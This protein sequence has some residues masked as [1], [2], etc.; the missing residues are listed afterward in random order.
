MDDVQNLNAAQNG[1][2][3]QNEMSGSE[4]VVSN[5]TEFAKYTIREI[6]PNEIDGLKLVHRRIIC[7]LGTGDTR[8]KGAKLVGNVMGDYHPHG[9]A[10]IYDAIIRLA[11]PFNQVAPYVESEGN[12]GK[13]GGG[14][15]AASRY[16]EV[17]PSEFTKDLFFSNVN[18]KTLT[19]VPNEIGDGYEPAYFVPVIPTALIT[20]AYGISVGYKSMIPHLNLINVCDLVLKWIELKN[21]DKHHYRTRY[22]DYAKYLIPDFPSHGYILNEKELLKEYGI[23]NFRCSVITCGTMEI[24]PTRINIRSIPY[25][26]DF[27]ENTKGKLEVLLKSASF[28]SSDYS[29]IIEMTTGKIL[30]NT[31]ITMKRGVDPF[32]H[33]DQ[34]KKTTSFCKSWTPIWNFCNE[35]GYLISHNPIELVEVWYNARVRSILADLKL[36]NVELVK[37]YRKVSALVIIYDHAKD[38]ANL[39]LKAKNKEETIAP[40][41]KKYNLSQFQAEYIA[42]L[43]IQQFTQQGK[44]ELLNQLTEIKNKIKELQTRFIKIDDIITSQ[45]IKIRDKYKSKCPRRTLIPDFIGALQIVGCGFVQF[46]SIQE[47]GQLISRWGNKDVNVILYPKSRFKLVLEK[48]GVFY[49]EEDTSFQKE[50]SGDVLHVIPANAKYTIIRRKDGTICRIDG[51]YPV[52]EKSTSV[53]YTGD[54]FITVDTDNQVNVTHYSDIV[55]RNNISATGNKSNIKFV[56]G[57]NMNSEYIVVSGNTKDPNILTFERIKPGGKF[58]KLFFGS[59]VIVGVYQP[60]S[61]IAFTVPKEL[62]ARCSVR[63]IYLKNISNILEDE[64]KVLVYLNKKTTSNK[65]TLCLIDKHAD[66]VTIK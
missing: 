60:N 24:H 51:L 66:I 54:D 8:I 27:R 58:T 46:S 13:Y 23:G 32:E 45:I 65:K 48:K 12:V 36:T 53:T 6:L 37:Q 40:L 63:H 57:I 34:L 11:Q 50:F 5:M 20:G 21:T 18:M 38:V 52:K 16:L 29:E 44:D 28:V 42:T 61:E 7:S 59:T 1:T 2:T 14:A 26:I 22:K 4:V 17:Y 10:S 3:F 33:L 30:G 19:Y 39:F 62:L 15:A 49:T 56:A 25:G 47:L 9:D 64:N 55:K 35:Q 31:E 43:Q 41:C